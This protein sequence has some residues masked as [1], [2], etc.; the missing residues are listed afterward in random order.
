MRFEQL[1]A[2][3]LVLSSESRFDQSFK[4]YPNGLCDHRDQRVRTPSHA[5]SHHLSKSVGCPASD[6]FLPEPFNIAGVEVGV[7]AVSAGDQID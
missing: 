7:K 4:P 2:N 5:C 6:D 1:N 3:D